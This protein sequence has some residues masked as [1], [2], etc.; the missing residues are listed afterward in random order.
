[1]TRIITTLCFYNERHY[2][3]CRVLLVVILSVIMLNVVMLM[4][5]VVMIGVVAAL[6]IMYYQLELYC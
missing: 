5:I 3:E 6:K 2:A 4:L 1:M